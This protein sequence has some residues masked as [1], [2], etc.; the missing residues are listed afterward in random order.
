M[1]LNHKFFLLNK[2][3]N[4]YKKYLGIK[5]DVNLHDDL[6]R[7]MID[8]LY[9]IPTENPNSEKMPFEGLDTYGVTIIK[10]EGANILFHI[11]SAWINLFSLSP[12]KLRLT[13]GWTQ[14]YNEEEQPEGEGSYET[15]EFDRDKV[16]INLKVLADYAQKASKGDYFVLHIG[17]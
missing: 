2:S 8:T 6:I 15:L 14:H 12:K 7:Y 10:N 13:G 1:G 3:E 4:S 9:W 5:S 11:I 16:I 17:I